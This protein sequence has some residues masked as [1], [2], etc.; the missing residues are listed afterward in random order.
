MVEDHFR[1]LKVGP[2]LTFAL[3]E[4][5]F[6]LSRIEKEFVSDDK[7]VQRSELIETVEKQMFRNPKF[8]SAHYHGDESS[9]RLA[10]KYSYSDR[11][12]YYWPNTAIQRSLNRLIGNLSKQEIPLTVL[13]QYL[14]LEYEAIREGKLQNH[15][16]DLIG[17]GITRVLET[18]SYATQ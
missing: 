2:W 4:T 7:N 10:R 3:R 8:W 17:F 9:L 13:S 1:I 11:I 12:R 16:S 15:I 18:Y 5:L 14:P 6:A